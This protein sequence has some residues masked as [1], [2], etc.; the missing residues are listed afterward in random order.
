MNSVNPNL[1]SVKYHEVPAGVLWE[2][3]GQWTL[4][5]LPVCILYIDFNI[6]GRTV[7]EFITTYDMIV[8]EMRQ[9]A[10]DSEFGLNE[11]G[12]SLCNVNQ[13]MS[14]TNSF[15]EL[16]RLVYL[17]EFTANAD[18][19]STAIHDFLSSVHNH[20]VSRLRVYPDRSKAKGKATSFFGLG[21]QSMNLCSPSKR[22]RF[23]PNRSRSDWKSNMNLSL[24][25]SLR[26]VWVGLK[27]FE[28]LLLKIVSPIR[29]ICQT[30]FSI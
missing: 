4:Q 9:L 23:R 24:S 28:I 19:I 2:K 12:L 30:I 11:F 22:F 10:N 8:A 29:S 18:N 1:P 3:Q 27:T 20:A 16:V 26:S 6:F 15:M 7:E 17:G 13:Y 25:L 14:L 5:F 21:C